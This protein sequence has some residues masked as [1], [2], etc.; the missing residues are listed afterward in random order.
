M[1]WAATN[2]MVLSLLLCGQ[3]DLWPYAKR[4]WKFKCIYIS[5]IKPCPVYPQLCVYGWD[6]D[7]YWP[8]RIVSSS[9]LFDQWIHWH[10]KEAARDIGNNT[11]I[12]P[13][14]FPWRI[15]LGIRMEDR[16]LLLGEPPWR[17]NV[18]LDWQRHTEVLTNHSPSQWSWGPS[19]LKPG[20]L[21]LL[22]SSRCAFLYRKR[23]WLRA[24]QWGRKGVTN[25]GNAQ[26]GSCEYHSES[27]L[28]CC[29]DSYGRLS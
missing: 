7:F 28:M 3:D 11:E 19:A 22:P 18:S 5:V 27:R 20:S 9:S 25:V 15:I 24:D 6:N 13:M 14:P 21:V 23:K 16:I 8:I 12:E 26:S 2:K 17:F 10:L 29:E 1:L 4:N